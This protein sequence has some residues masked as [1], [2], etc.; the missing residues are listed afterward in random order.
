MKNIK[1]SIAI[2]LDT[3]QMLLDLGNM[4]DSFDDVIKKLIKSHSSCTC[5]TSQES[6]DEVSE[7]GKSLIE[8]HKKKEGWE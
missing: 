5:V 2:S 8:E 4:D 3:R 6:K 1:T 7:V